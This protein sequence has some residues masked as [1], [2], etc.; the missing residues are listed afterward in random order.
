MQLNVEDDRIE[1]EPDQAARAS[2]IWLHGLGADGYDFEGVIPLLELPAG[3]AVRFVFPH[4]PVRPVT[5]NNGLEMRAWFDICGLEGDAPQDEPGVR[6]SAERLQRLVEREVERG[7]APERIVLAGFSQGGA[8]A[9]HAGLRSPE[10]LAGIL[11]LSAWLPLA[12]RLQDEAVAARRRTPILMMHGRDDPVVS[13]QVAHLSRD[14]LL[15]YGC[16]VEF[17][18]LAMGH[19]ISAEQLTTIGAWLRRR[20]SL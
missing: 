5:V 3:A 16:D 19:S 17:Q 7:V 6:D 11:A 2:V 10:P 9:L 12:D 8:V 18:I 20:L 4:A 14:R 13:L 1:V 15:Q